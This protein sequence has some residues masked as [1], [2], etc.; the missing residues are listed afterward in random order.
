MNKK[1]LLVFAIFCLPLCTFAQ[2]AEKAEE[3]PADSTKKTIKVNT[4]WYLDDKDRFYTLYSYAVPIPFEKGIL[5][6]AKSGDF[7]IGF[8]YRNYI[9][10]KIALGGELSYSL[11][12]SR[13]A[14]DSMGIFSDTLT[15]LSFSPKKITVK[16]HG[17]GVT[18]FLRI[19]FMEYDKAG[20]V[21][22]DL[23]GFYS[24]AF[25]NNNMIY[26]NKDYYFIKKDVEYVGN[27]SFGPFI[28]LSLDDL[29]ALYFK[30]DFSKWITNY[31]PNNLDYS[32]PNLLIGLQINL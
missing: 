28:R 31:G 5:N 26:R 30:Y 14:K 9:T 12:F 7:N 10:K 11:R 15:M 23:G 16:S 29:C 2:N 6:S 27:H 21:S 25:G 4:K 17:L 8:G 1:F 22:M 19:N 13:I 18:L 24:Y 20:N 32:R 3:N